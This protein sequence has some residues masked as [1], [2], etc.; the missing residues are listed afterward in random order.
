M[1]I[2]QRQ[3][4]GAS[5]PYGTRGEP[6][7]D[8]FADLR[9]VELDGLHSGFTLPRMGCTSARSEMHFHPMVKEHMLNSI[10]DRSVV[11]S[12]RRAGEVMRLT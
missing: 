11:H 7:P 12:A 2:F 10:G 6:L 1:A 8:L 3:S 4:R 5:G 9:R